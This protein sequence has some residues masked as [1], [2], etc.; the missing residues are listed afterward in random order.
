MPEPSYSRSNRWLTVILITPEE[1]GVDREA[2]RLALER[3]NI[4]SRPVW[5]PMIA[6]IAAR[7][8]DWT[9]PV[10]AL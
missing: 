2:V 5:K 4:E 10:P 3:E 6:R 1:F 8:K 9:L 7:I